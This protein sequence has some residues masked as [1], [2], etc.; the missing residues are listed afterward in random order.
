LAADLDVLYDITVDVKI[1]N[2]L[3][4]TQWVETLDAHR[5]WRGELATV[6]W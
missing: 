3:V 6:A 4:P 2:Y 5:R 1:E